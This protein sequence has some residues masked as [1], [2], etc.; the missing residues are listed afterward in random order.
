MLRLSKPESG[1]IVVNGEWTE[2]GAELDLRGSAVGEEGFV[3]E[4]VEEKENLERLG[5]TGVDGRGD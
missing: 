5:T 3:K 1:C 2:V 4:D